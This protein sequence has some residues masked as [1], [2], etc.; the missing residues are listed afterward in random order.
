MKYQDDFEYSLDVDANVVSL[1]VIC[2]KILHFGKI[3]DKVKIINKLY[4]LRKNELALSGLE[5][6]LEELI[7]LYKQNCDS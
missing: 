3:E 2:H 6:S 7:D 1:C 4:E 5:I